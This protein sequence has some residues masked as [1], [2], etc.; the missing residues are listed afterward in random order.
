MSLWSAPTNPFLDGSPGND[1]FHAE[2][3]KR[4]RWQVH[5]PIVFCGGPGPVIESVTHDLSSD[6]FYCLAGAPFVP[7]EVRGCTLGVPAYYPNDLTRV[8]PVQCR[9]RVVRVEALAERGLFGVGCRIE[10][11]R[12]DSATSAGSDAPH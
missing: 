9:V 7:G 3:R 2:R 1:L 6:G 8:V 10:D 5:W 12:V 4:A 11:Y